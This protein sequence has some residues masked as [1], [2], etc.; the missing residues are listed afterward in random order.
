MALL[1]ILILANM[2]QL[3][4]LICKKKIQIEISKKNNCLLMKRFGKFH[5]ILIIY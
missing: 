1:E 2:C 3:K 4:R 5:K